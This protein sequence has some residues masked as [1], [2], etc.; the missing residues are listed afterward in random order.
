VFYR[1]LSYGCRRTSCGFHCWVRLRVVVASSDEQTAPFCLC[2]TPMIIVP[3][4]ILIVVRLYTLAGTRRQ[5]V[6]IG[7]LVMSPTPS[8]HNVSPS[9]VI[10]STTPRLHGMIINTSKMSQ[11]AKIISYPA[12]LRHFVFDTL[13]FSN[14]V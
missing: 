3:P 5:G 10:L 13:H 14:K 12:R 1:Q 11:T 9:C 7:S 2:T 4:C 8:A 6:P